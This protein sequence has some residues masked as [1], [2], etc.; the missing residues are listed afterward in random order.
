MYQL[1][2]LLVGLNPSWWW[3][4]TSCS[5]KLSDCALAHV[6]HSISGGPNDTEYRQMDQMTTYPKSKTGHS[7]KETVW[8]CDGQSYI[9]IDIQANDIVSILESY[10]KP[11]AP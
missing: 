8:N 9:G 5:T 10:L 2:F 1:L 3:V 7:K 6:Q 4:F 11:G